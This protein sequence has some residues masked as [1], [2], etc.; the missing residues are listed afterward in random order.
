MDVDVVCRLST[1]TYIWKLSC[2]SL[3]HSIVSLFGYIIKL[4]NFFLTKEFWTKKLTLI[5]LIEDHCW[6]NFN[7]NHCLQNFKP[8]II[9]FGTFIII[10]SPIWR[11]FILRVV[12]SHEWK[13]MG[14]YKATYCLNSIQNLFLFVDWINWMKLK[15]FLDWDIH[16]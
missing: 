15:W 11:I 2:A 9:H 12:K 10:Q 4:L 5:F 3:L 1:V 13:V 6:V 8:I 14:S 16:F 7:V